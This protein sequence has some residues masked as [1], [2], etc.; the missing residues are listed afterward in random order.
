MSG[1]MIQYG[2]KTPDTDTAAHSRCRDSEA[3][4][5][6]GIP[7]TVSSTRIANVSCEQCSHQGN[8]NLTLIFTKFSEGLL[9]SSP[10]CQ[11][12]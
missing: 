9:A 12:L 10:C 5:F 1:A 4:Y 8:L 2:P 6:I 11:L 7:D 3:G